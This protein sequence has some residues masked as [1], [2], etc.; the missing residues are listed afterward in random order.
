[1]NKL[2]LTAT[3]FMDG[4]YVA[5][6]LEH[7]G[8]V[9]IAGNLGMLQFTA[10][11]VTGFLIIGDGSNIEAGEDIE[12]G[13]FIEAGGSIKAGGSI[14]AGWSIEAGLSIFCKSLIVKLRIFAGLIAC[15]LPK[16]HEQIISC[17]KLIYGTVAYGTL[18][19]RTPEAI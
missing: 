4:K 3:D 2:Y 14:E 7:A 15:R 18:V 11:R 5:G 6:R 10:I 12:T 8:D 9:K 16:P 19:I 17:E 13:E 1:M